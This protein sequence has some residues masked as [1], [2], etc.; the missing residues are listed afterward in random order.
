MAKKTSSN[1][2]FGNFDDKRKMEVAGIFIIALS[3][4]LLLSIASYHP[5]DYAI[6]K[7]LTYDSILSADQNQSLMVQN[8]LN[9]VG[10]YIAF[11]LVHTMFGYVSILFPIIGTS[12]GWVVFRQKDAG[13][14]NGW[15]YRRLC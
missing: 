10:A 1:T 4:L 6:V 5:D 9:V 12:V 7:S 3:F 15:Q 2:S 13:L 14:L 11:L 8:W